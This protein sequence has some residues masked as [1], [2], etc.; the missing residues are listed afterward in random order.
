MNIKN[1]IR[2][3]R[4]KYR[5]GTGLLY[6]S[7]PRDFISDIG[8]SFGKY[9]PKYQNLSYFRYQYDQSPF[10]ICTQAGS[11]LALS[12]QLSI[13]LSIKANT[14]KVKANGKISRDGFASQRAPLDVICKDGVIPI[15]FM[16]DDTNVSWSNF[17]D[18]DESTRLL[19][20]RE[21]LFAGLGAYKKLTSESAVWE[22]RELGFVP[23]L[24]GKWFSYDNRPKAPR[25]L[26]RFLGDYIGGHQYRSSGGREKIEHEDGQTF[27][28]GYGDSGKAYEKSYFTSNHYDVYIIEFDGKPLPPMELLLP[29]FLYQHEGLMVKAHD[30]HGQPECY[31]IENGQKR[32]VSGADNMITFQKLLTQVGLTRVNR[33]VLRAVP[34]G[35]QYPFI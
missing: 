23:V 17:S 20:A 29:T 2:A 34:L 6:E 22:A 31:V 35:E 12:E 11:I 18:Y 19:Y 28:P 32:W 33:E 25:F 26:M 13:R 16:P 27:G 4:E 10:N 5:G 3:T 14:R 30:H 15:E 21:A 1:Y 24:A 7:D 8:I 9:E